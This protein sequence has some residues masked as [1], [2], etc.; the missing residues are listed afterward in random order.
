MKPIMLKVLEVIIPQFIK[1]IFK[2]K[3]KKR[4]IIQLEN[5]D[6]FSTLVRV[7][8]EVANLKF[9]TH[10]EYDK[11]KTRM[12]YDFT[13]HKSIKCSV[14]MLELIRTRGIDE[15]DRDE[16][17]KLILDEQN[18]MHREYIKSIRIEWDLKGVDP[19]DVDYV[20]HLF[21]KFRYDVIVSFEHRI[22][23][24]FGSSYNKDNFSLMLAVLEMWAMGIDLLPRDMQTTFESLNGKFK[25]I[26]YLM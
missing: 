24:I 14:R 18:Y 26:K 3:E 25:D 8:N 17:K 9:Y 2:K 20:I 13:K 11:I 19:Q 1:T 21:E 5:H 23:S 16:L 15:M 22:N 4:L 7:R 6:V 10:G 12:C